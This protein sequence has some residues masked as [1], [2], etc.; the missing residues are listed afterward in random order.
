MKGAKE[1]KWEQRGVKGGKGKQ[2][3]VKGAKGAKGSEGNCILG[4]RVPTTW[5]KKV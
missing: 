4:F 3:E 2:R 5:N 1:S